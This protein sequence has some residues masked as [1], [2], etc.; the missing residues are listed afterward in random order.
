MRIE[1]VTWSN[2]LKVPVTHFIC[3]P[4]NEP[5]IME[6]VE[7]FKRK[8][9]QTCSKV[10]II[11]FFFVI[12][13]VMCNNSMSNQSKYDLNQILNKLPSDLLSNNDR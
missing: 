5:S 3:I 10:S 11:M 2:R 8:A 12:I 13:T 1:V 4:L 7:V 9:L 6:R